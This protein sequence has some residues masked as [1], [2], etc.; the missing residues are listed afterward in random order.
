MN[1]PIKHTEKIKEYITK[2]ML[3]DELSNDSL[4]QIIELCGGFLN[5]QSISNYAKSNN[6]SY[7]GVKKCRNVIILFNNKYIIDNN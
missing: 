4:V 6:L 3:K 2:V 1:K 7:N 5:L